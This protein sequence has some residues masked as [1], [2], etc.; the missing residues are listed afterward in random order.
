[1]ASDPYLVLDPGIR[2]SIGAGPGLKELQVDTN[3][4]FNLVPARTG[5]AMERATGGNWG[6]LPRGGG[7]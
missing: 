3:T 1:M 7:V 4:G 6:R 5:G 2:E